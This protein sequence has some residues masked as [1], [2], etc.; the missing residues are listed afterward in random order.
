MM[1]AT[2]FLLAFVQLQNVTELWGSAYGIVLLL[3]IAV[4]LPLFCLAAANRFVLTA[5]VARGE[6]AARRWMA[7]SVFGE[8]LLAALVVGVI[9][10]WRFTPPPRE[11][12]SGTGDGERRAN[13]RARYRG[14]G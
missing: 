10:L 7:R 4:L 6:Q 8:A 3:K 2:G 13:A 5:R 14:H 11:M 12:S 1:P 9:G